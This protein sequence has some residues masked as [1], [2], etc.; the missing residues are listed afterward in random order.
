ME[1][2]FLSEQE[3]GERFPGEWVLVEEAELDSEL[4]VV[5][6]QI[7]AHDRSKSVVEAVAQARQSFRS[8]QPFIIRFAG[9]LPDAVYLLSGRSAR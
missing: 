3:I 4:R 2:E 5:R 6:G 9:E 7:A 8:S 1:Q